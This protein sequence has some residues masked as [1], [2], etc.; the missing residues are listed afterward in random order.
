MPKLTLVQFTSVRLDYRGEIVDRPTGSAEIFTEDLGNGVEL[1][2][3]KIPAS[4]FIM[5]SPASEKGQFNI[6]TES[7]Q[8]QVNNSGFYLGQTQVNQ[9]Q[10]QAIMCNNPSYLKGNDRLPVERA[11]WLDAMPCFSLLFH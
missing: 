3:V 1:T 2:M 6:N 7:P 11:S 9:A 5:G 10:W 8:H 4:K